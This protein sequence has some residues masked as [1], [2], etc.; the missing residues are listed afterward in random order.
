MG[1][2]AL[3]EYDLLGDSKYR[4]WW[5]I[6]LG[7][8]SSLLL[9]LP[10]PSYM[11]QVDRA[12]RG[13][14]ST[15]EWA[16]LIAALTKLNRWWFPCQFKPLCHFFTITRVLL[17]HMKYPVVPRRVNILTL[18]SIPSW[19]TSVRL[20]YQRGLPNACT[21]LCHLGFIKKHWKPMI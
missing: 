16:D 17:A 14:E 18:I 11:T 1:S 10:P 13:F 6:L 3:E 15:S 7:V 20:W 8:L 2:I 21:Q 12:L 5:E 9:C 19:P 4:R